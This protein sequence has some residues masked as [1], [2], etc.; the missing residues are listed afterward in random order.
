M[1]ISRVE[2]KDFIYNIKRPDG[3]HLRTSIIIL[4]K[5]LNEMK[6]GF[7]PLIL[8]VG[9]QRSGKSFFALWL[10]LQ[11][12]NFFKRDFD[13]KRNTF[14]D[15]MLAIRNLNKLNKEVVILD[16]SG[17]YLHNKEFFSKVNKATEKIIITQG[18]LCNCYIFCVPFASSINKG[19]RKEFN[20]VVTMKKE[21]W[22]SF[23]KFQK[24]IMIYQA[25][26]QN[27]IL[28]KP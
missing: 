19:I 2:E 27:R 24:T 25:H 12:M 28:L 3:T 17:Y 1:K 11:I 4:G 8:I 23:A 21:V 18:Y 14:Y 26:N 6:K 15:P 10:A 9:K 5:I 16:E 20:F 13:F 22:Q 7:S